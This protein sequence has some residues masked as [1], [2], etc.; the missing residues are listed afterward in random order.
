VP[1]LQTAPPAR[2]RDDA[3]TLCWR[4][5]G[6][7]RWSIA[8]GTVFES[9]SIFTAITSSGALIGAFDSLTSAARALPAAG[10]ASS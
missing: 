4:W 8:T 9:R 2:K 1:S 5:R 10:R 3:P 7:A 6:N